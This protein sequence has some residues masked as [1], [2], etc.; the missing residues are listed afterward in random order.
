[1]DIQKDMI[2]RISNRSSVVVTMIDSIVERLVD[3]YKVDKRKIVVI[4]HGVPDIPFGGTEHFKRL[5][6]L[7][8]NFVLSSINLISPNKGLE[9]AIE[10]VPAIVKKVP[11]FTYLIVGET[12]PAVKKK[13][14]EEYRNS[15]R[16]LIK[17]LGVKRHVEFVNQYLSLEDL[18]NYLRASDVYTTPYLDPQQVASGTL[19]YAVGAGKAC[20]STPYIYAQ[21]VLGDSRGVL[22]PFRDSKAIAEAIIRLHSEPKSKS[23]IERKAYDYGRIMTWPAVA[24]QYL[25]LFMLVLRKAKLRS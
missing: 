18:L 10:A 1:L 16:N 2:K 24:L 13:F 3:T 19:S 8:K 5:L 22:V 21:E 7:R 17:K 23:Q 4:P 14:G 15:L 9:Y 6:K 11:N 20:V 12:H 25:D